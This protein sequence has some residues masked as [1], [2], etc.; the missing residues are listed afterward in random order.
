MTK[1]S[2]TIKR[3]TDTEMFYHLHGNWWIRVSRHGE[4]LALT[5]RRDL[6]QDVEMFL[7]NW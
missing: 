6:H 4:S 1:Q 5:S 3:L 2:V 7:G